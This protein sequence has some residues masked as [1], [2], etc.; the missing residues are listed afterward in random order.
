MGPGVDW[1]PSDETLPARVDVVVI[2]GGIIG[3]SAAL[4]LAQQGISVALCEKGQ[5]AHEQSSRNWGWCRKMARDPRE[6]PLA[7]ESLRMW[8]GMNGMVEA[9]TGFRA[10]GIMY[11]AQ[12]QAD[13]ARFEAWLDHA[14]EYQLDSRIIGSAE[15]A[16]RLPGIAKEYTGA[17]FTASDGKAEPQMAA[18]AIARAARRHGATIMTGCAVRGI[19]TAVGRVASVVTERGAIACTSVVL[20]GGAWSHLFCGNLGIELPQLGVL[21]SVMRTERLD[22][23]PEISAAGRRFGYRKRM[24]GGYTVSSVGERLVDLVPDSFRLLRHYLPAARIHW[25]KLRFR[26]GRRFV[27]EWRTPRRWNLDAPSPFE[28]IRV[29]DPAPD[30]DLIEQARG[31]IADTFPAFRNIPVAETW[32][33]MIDVMPDAIPVISAV[34]KVPGFFIATGFSG[35]GFGIGPGAGRLIAEMVMGM[36]PLVDPTPF[37]LSR[38]SDGSNPKPHPLA[39]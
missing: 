33:G 38:F 34:D 5:I 15:I 18:P 8:E 20:A 27:D 4:F 36:P 31:G 22:G 2:G 3:T 21:G 32:G 7:I 13:L 39:S 16:R 29:L 24:D 23:G 26:L 37:R 6:L 17:L 10:S 11:L 25:K 19:E 1:V 30:R 14:R 35:H 28:Q 12:T 9:E